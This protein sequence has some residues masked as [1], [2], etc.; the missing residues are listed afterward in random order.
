METLKNFAEITEPDERNRHFDVVD[1]KGVARKLT[2]QDIHQS[3]S[4][5][6][7]HDSVPED[8][9]SHFAQAQNLAVYS[10]FQYQFNVTA[11]LM[12]FVTVEYALK[13]KTGTK[14][15]FKRLIEQAIAEGWIQDD[16]FSIA[17][18]RE[19]PEGSYVEVLARVMPSL[20]NDLAHGTEM[21]HNNA[22]SSLRICAEFINQ[23]FD[24]PES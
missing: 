19:N 5:I 14:A 15:N 4:S 3:V 10:W 21:L 2:L 24:L 22:L 7:L 17:K 16:G 11:Q 9:R 1:G 12:G 18:L 8:I 20:R 23:L 6:S 13:R